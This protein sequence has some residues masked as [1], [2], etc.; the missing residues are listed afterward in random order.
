M[1]ATAGVAA[2]A[3]L[4]MLT[5]AVAQGCKP[6]V[7]DADL[8]KPGTLTMSTNP[9]LPPLQFVDSSGALKGMRVELG[10]A[11]ANRLCLKP[12][13]VRIDFDAMVPGLQAGRWDMINTG[14]F[15]TPA[16]A[17]I[18]QM[19]PNEQQAISFSVPKA[20]A[21]KI[22]KV[23]DLAGKTVGV[24]IGGF[25]EQKTREIDR[26]LTAKSLPGLTVRT[27]DSFAAAYQAL[28]AG[29][30]DA[31]VSIDAVAKAYQDRGVFARPLTGLFPTP[32]SFAFKNRALAD[33]VAKVLGE[34][35][36][37]GSYDKLFAQYGLPLFP[38]PF[39]V[40]GPG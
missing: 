34:M 40:H 37:D 13:Y 36:A 33:A 10:I 16:R 2:L 28:G 18:M 21:G 38:G 39:Q 35:K 7:P 26:Q 12:D 9:T 11:V 3:L 6:A 15:F 19:I 23:E 17:R 30:L 8:V 22:A 32:V 29:Q 4:G 25:E 14:I 20:S 24:E 31:V 1:G 27:F 5:P